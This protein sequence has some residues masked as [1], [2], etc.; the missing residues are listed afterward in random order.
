M[1]RG[2]LVILFILGMGILAAIISLWTHYRGGQ[3]A[4]KYLGKDDALLLRDAK[5]VQLVR[6]RPAPEDSVTEDDLW[7]VDGQ[8]WMVEQRF[9]VTHRAGLLYVRESLLHDSTFDW[10]Q[11]PKDCQSKWLSV[12]VFRSD[13]NQLKLIF[14]TQCQWMRAEGNS[15]PAISIAPAITFF[16]DWLNHQLPP[17]PP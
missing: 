14:D 6:L 9:D 16:A 1:Q 15:R 13:K 3:R 2:K 7:N 17:L 4:L 12:L 8:P 5:T 10:S 11:Q